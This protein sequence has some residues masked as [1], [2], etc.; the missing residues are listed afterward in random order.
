MIETKTVADLRRAKAISHML[1]TYL[2]SAHPV[3]PFPLGISFLWRCP[4]RRHQISRFHRY[5][6][7]AASLVPLPADKDGFLSQ[8]V[9][10]ARSRPSHNYPT[11]QSTSI[12]GQRTSIPFFPRISSVMRAVIADGAVVPV[13]TSD[14]VRS[15]AKTLMPS[16]NRSPK[17]LQLRNGHWLNVRLGPGT[18][19]AVSDDYSGTGGFSH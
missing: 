4:C 12:S 8:F 13:A 9:G 7:P 14:A 5:H 19:Q 16:P 6:V 1:S 3:P 10:P 17:R 2:D 11:T 15:G 18:L